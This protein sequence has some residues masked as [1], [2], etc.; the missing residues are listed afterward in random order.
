MNLGE[1]IAELERMPQDL[2]VDGFSNPHSYRG[3]YDD[4]AFEPASGVTIGA[5]LR[6]C[7]SALG[8]TFQGHKGGDYEMGEYTICWLAEHGSYGDPIYPVWLRLIVR[9]AELKQ[10][11]G[12]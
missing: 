8:A 4:L 3:F 2:V 10:E 7:R 5:M 11:A 9:E 1:L 12:R 6:D